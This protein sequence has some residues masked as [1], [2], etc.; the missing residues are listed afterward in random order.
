MSSSQTD[1]VA[2]RRTPAR[3]A[4]GVL[5]GLDLHAQYHSTRTGGD[6]FDALAVGSRV[7]FFLTDIAGSRQVADPIAAAAQ[8]KFR[9]FA[10]EFFDAEDT[11]LMDSTA[12][13]VQEIN[14]ALIGASGAQH[15]APT[16][17]GCYDLQL[18][19]LAYINAGGLTA[20][21][22]DADG[23]RALP[24]VA[25]PMGLFSHFTY[26]PS[27]QAFEPGA[28]LLIVTKGVV[29]SSHCTEPFGAER[30]SQILRES[31]GK[32]AA[33]ICQ[34]TL[35]AAYGFRELPWYSPRRLG[36]HRD[37]VIDDLTALAMMRD[38]A[39]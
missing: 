36:W 14:R 22:R 28:G 17:V 33:A 31:Q 19:V 12:L 34:T 30:V 6:F 32:S 35:D 29:E 37:A 21:L 39:Q 24:N 7:I 2:I 3:A 11:N 38:S 25:V 10:A 18:G 20:I 4:V 27:M 1:S 8:D 16:F 23:T 15:F 9:Q 5:E 13:L 26:E